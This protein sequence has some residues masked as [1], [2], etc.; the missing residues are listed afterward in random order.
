LR[1]GR[2]G[3]VAQHGVER[4]ELVEVAM[5]TDRRAGPAIAGALPVV[6]SLTGSRRESPRLRGP[7]PG[8]GRRGG[9]VEG[10]LHPRHLGCRRV[11]RIGIIDD[12]DKALGARGRITPRER[13]RYISAFTGVALRNRAAGDE[14]G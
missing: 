6:A 7:A 3:E 10:P 13:R 4:V 11:R 9:V 1:L 12:E 8:A 5:P 2:L 14:S